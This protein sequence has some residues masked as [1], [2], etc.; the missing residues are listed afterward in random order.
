MGAP[1]SSLEWKHDVHS[2]NE[3]NILTSSINYEENGYD[4]DMDLL[5]IVP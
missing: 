2:D 3:K 4:F 1:V 5:S